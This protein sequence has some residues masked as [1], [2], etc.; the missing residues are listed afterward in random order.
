VPGVR[1]GD[2]FLFAPHGTVDA[3]DA[4]VRANV[5]VVGALR[6]LNADNIQ[7]NR[8][9]GLPTVPTT[10]TAALTAADK[11]AA[12][13]SKAME[14]PKACN[15]DHGKESHRE[16]AGGNAGT[17]VDMEPSRCGIV[18]S[19]RSSRRNPRSHHSHARRSH[20]NLGNHRSLGNREQQQ[21]L[22]ACC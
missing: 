7:A 4:G 17:A 20:G 15:S 3:G 1:Q 21:R 16:P 12:A 2:V 13:A 19:V 10:S 14:S 22:A 5:A 9:I 8:S 18:P 11:T 6:V